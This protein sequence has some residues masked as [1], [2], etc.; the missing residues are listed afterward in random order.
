M[1]GVIAPSAYIDVNTTGGFSAR[2]DEALLGGSAG[3]NSQLPRPPVRALSP[4][5]KLARDSPDKVKRQCTNVPCCIVFIFLWGLATLSIYRRSKD[6]EYSRLLFLQDH[7][8]KDCNFDN[9]TGRPNTVICAYKKNAVVSLPLFHVNHAGTTMSP[10]ALERED[11]IIEES[12]ELKGLRFRLVCVSECPSTVEVQYQQCAP[13]KPSETDDILPFNSTRVSTF[14]VPNFPYVRQEFRQE[15]SYLSTM[16]I[17]MFYTFVLQHWILLPFPVIWSA[18]CCYACM[19]FLKYFASC[20]LSM[21]IIFVYVSCFV[22]G[23]IFLGVWYISGHHLTNF[24]LI[25]SF[26]ACYVIGASVCCFYGKQEKSIAMAGYAINAACECVY[27]VW[28]LLLHP[29]IALLMQTVLTGILILSLIIRFDSRVGPGSKGFDSWEDGAL[30]WSEFGFCAIMLLWVNEFQSACSDFLYMYVSQVWFFRGAERASKTCTWC[31]VGTALRYH[32]GSLALGSFVTMSLRPV[33]TLVALVGSTAQHEDSVL[34]EIM[35]SCCCC[36]VECYNCLQPFNKGAYEGIAHNGAAYCKSA[37]A[38]NDILGRKATAV[39]LLNGATAL[40]QA[41]ISIGLTLTVFFIS[42]FALPFVCSFYGDLAE[43][44]EGT[45]VW[46]LRVQHSMALG[47]LALL[48]SKPFLAAFDAVSDTLIYCISLH[49]I[50]VEMNVY[51]DACEMEMAK[52]D[53]FVHFATDPVR[54]FAEWVGVCARPRKTSELLQL[55]VGDQLRGVN[56]LLEDED[57]LEEEEQYRTLRMEADSHT[58]R[59]AHATNKVCA[60]PEDADN[61]PEAHTLP[62]P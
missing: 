34:G 57:F 48:A 37:Y 11:M 46:V 3:H 50:E 9:N 51:G 15:Y 18:V 49:S 6:L 59:F 41:A 10:E 22:G 52:N 32:T 38:T 61:L 36:I 16:M 27:D 23:T 20:F 12:Y 47:F 14:C 30:T 1:R 54:N 40:F 62:P 17:D 60:N 13:H 21:V 42:F 4:L 55:S 19:L 7:M 56:T 28:G 44:E 8:G 35:R 39:H 33:R 58:Q 45:F 5:E 2:D 29:F 31:V 53:T 24:P 25:L 26:S 43:V